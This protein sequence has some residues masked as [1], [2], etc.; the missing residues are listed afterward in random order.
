MIVT[1]AIPCHG[2][3]AEYGEK[4]VQTLSALLGWSHFKE[5]EKGELSQG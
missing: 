3:R 1:E 2:K 5:V 4:I